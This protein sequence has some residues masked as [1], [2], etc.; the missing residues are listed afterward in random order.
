MRL[1]LPTS[2]LSLT[3]L[4]SVF[5][6]PTLDHQD[7]T[8]PATDTLSIQTSGP[9]APK[10]DDADPTYTTFNGIQVPPLTELEGPT[11]K[12]AVKDGYWF[13]K[14][15]SPNCFHCR[16]IAPAWQTL[17]EFYYVCHGNRPTLVLY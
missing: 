11:F 16:A 6:A 5:A 1:L 3:V 4:S 8:T 12:E 15:Y 17:Y 13:V 10:G 7:A 2:L 9:N 14:H